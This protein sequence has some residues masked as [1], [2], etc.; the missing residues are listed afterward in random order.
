MD[1]GFAFNPQDAG[2]ACTDTEV[3]MSGEYGENE[4]SFV[5][6]D[7]INADCNSGCHP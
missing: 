6:L 4:E 5:G 3:Q 1:A 7:T 2:I